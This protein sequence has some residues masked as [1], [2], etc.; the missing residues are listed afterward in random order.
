MSKITHNKK[1][2]YKVNSNNSR[3]DLVPVAKNSIDFKYFMLKCPVVTCSLKIY[4]NAANA[5]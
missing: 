3:H 2:E 1:I 5:T 4:L